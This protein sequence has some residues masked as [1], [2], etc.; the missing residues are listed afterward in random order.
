VALEQEVLE[1]KVG[2][3]SITI[4]WLLEFCDRKWKPKPK[5]I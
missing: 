3:L 1:E 2:P 5:L 4:C